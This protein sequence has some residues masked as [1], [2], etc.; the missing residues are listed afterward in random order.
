MGN[1]KEIIQTYCSINKCR[2]FIFSLKVRSVVIMSHDIGRMRITL[3]M[4]DLRRLKKLLM[5]RLIDIVVMEVVVDYL[6]SCGVIS[7]TG[8]ENKMHF[9][10]IKTYN[11][12]SKKNPLNFTAKNRQLGVQFKTVEYTETFCIKYSKSQLKYGKQ[13]NL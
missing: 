12:H 13:H 2:S 4:M 6:W 7:E 3:T 8:P 5:V 10:V 11:T 1:I 9:L